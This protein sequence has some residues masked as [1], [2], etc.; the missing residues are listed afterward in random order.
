[1]SSKTGKWFLYALVG[2]SFWGF[3]G[4]AS[5]A[6]FIRYHFSAIL[7]SSLR[8]LI[9]GIFIIIIFR[10]G[11]PRKDVKN[12]LVF[13]FAGLMPVQISYIE[14][15]KYTNAATATLIQYLFLPIIFIYEIFK[16]IIR[17]DR[18]IIIST[19]FAIFGLIELISGFPFSD[20]NILINIYGIIFGMISAVTAAAYII[21]SGNV[22]SKNGSSS[23]IGYALLIGGIVTL[24][25]SLNKMYLFDSYIKAEFIGVISLILFIGIIGTALS[26]WLVISSREKVSSTKTSIAATMEPFMA[27]ITSSTFLNI[28]LKP[29]QYL[30]FALIIV[31]VIISTKS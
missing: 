13:T 2:S 21:M 6:L 18:Y 22:I 23:S 3:S 26:F 29:V 1:M 16:K 28:F 20:K 27:A 8:M 12:F 15:I 4:T 25:F 14:T 19:A 7:L 24:P 30:G 31:S 17:V 9:G 11:I 5:S 10:A